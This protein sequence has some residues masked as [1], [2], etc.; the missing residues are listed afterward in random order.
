MCVLII[1]LL[2]MEMSGITGVRRGILIPIQVNQ[3]INIHSKKAIKGPGE[4]L[5]TCG[6]VA[7]LIYRLKG[8]EVLED[9]NLSGSNG[10]KEC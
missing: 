2:Q 10:I 7:L 6:K 4:V 3:D 9:L 5:I 8:T 1:D